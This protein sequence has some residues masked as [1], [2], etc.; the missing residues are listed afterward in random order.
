MSNLYKEY[1]TEIEAKVL[2]SYEPKI[3]STYEEDIKKYSE[4]FNYLYR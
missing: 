1:V 3:K 2:K 4:S